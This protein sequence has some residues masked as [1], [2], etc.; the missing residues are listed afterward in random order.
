MSWLDRAKGAAEIVEL[1]TRAWGAVVDRNRANQA[2]DE[3]I[4]ELDRR[5]TELEEKKP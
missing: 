4:K 5:V 3:R 1:L 2:R